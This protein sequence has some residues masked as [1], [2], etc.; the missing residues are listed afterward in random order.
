[1][2]LNFNN[3]FKCGIFVFCFG[4]WALCHTHR[5]TLF[6]LY[7]PLVLFITRLPT[8]PNRMNSREREI[9]NLSLWLSYRFNGTYGNTRGLRLI[10]NF[11]FQ[12][13]ILIC[14]ICFRQFLFLMLWKCF[15]FFFSYRI[16]YFWFSVFWSVSFIIYFWYFQ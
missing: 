6:S 14:P 9:T 5:H 12:F 2:R 7:L 13:R 8:K 15:L 3:K 16:N 1:M 10:F 4:G 11:Q